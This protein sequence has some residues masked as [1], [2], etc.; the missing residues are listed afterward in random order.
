M[1]TAFGSPCTR[2]DVTLDVDVAIW[3]PTRQ[4]IPEFWTGTLAQAANEMEPVPGHALMGRLFTHERAGHAT[5]VWSEVER[6]V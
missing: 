2:V 5:H 6:P 4:L 3:Y 1:M